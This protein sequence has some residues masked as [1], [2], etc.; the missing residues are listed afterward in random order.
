MDEH[1]IQQEFALDG[2]IWLNAAHQGPLPRVAVQAVEDQCRHKAAPWRI[3]DD[4]FTA[5]PDKLRASIAA[6][7][8]AQPHDIILGNS[9]SYGI[10]LLACALPWKP[11]DEVLYVE[12]EFPASIFPWLPAATRGL[13]TRSFRTQEGNIPTPDELVREL[14]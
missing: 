14:L 5:V 9:A 3:S 7:I 13:S 8:D 12:G 6:L 4:D 2:H 10:D 1:A 11:G